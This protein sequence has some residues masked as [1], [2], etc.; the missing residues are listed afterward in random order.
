MQQALEM[1]HLQELVSHRYTVL[2]SQTVLTDGGH[3]YASPAAWVYLDAQWL[4]TLL[5]FDIACLPQGWMAVLVLLCGSFWEGVA[6]S[7]WH[8]CVLYGADWQVG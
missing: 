3:K 6:G 5:H 4:Y 7:W 8:M 1:T 2:G